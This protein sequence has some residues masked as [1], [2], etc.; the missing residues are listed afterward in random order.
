[1]D[2]ETLKILGTAAGLG[3]LVGLQKEIK[4][5][6]MAGIRTFTL[7]TLFGT[8][9]G[10]LAQHLEEGFIIA[11]GAVCLALLISIVNFRMPSNGD[12]GLGQTTEVALL[13]MYALGAYL[14]YGQLAIGVGVGA[15]TALLLYM[16][17]TLGE[18]VDR[19][20]PK[21]IRAIMQF[22]AISLVILPIL[23][24]QTFGPYGVLNPR[25]IW[26]MVVL[27]VGLG[28]IG[29][30]IYKW[31]GND[32][33]TILNGI[34]GGLISSTATT[35]TFS[36]RAAQT[37]KAS[38]V[39]AFIVMAASTIAVVR[40]LI[41]VIIVSPSNIGVIGPP[42]LVELAFMLLLCAGLYWYSKKQET[43]KLPEPQ[44]PAQLK[45]ALIFGALYAV[46]LLAVAAG[47]DFFG[48]NGLYIVSI[49]SG[50]TDVDAITLSL[51]NS[52]N[53]GNLANTVAWKLILIAS[54]S[55][56]IFKGGLVVT[57]GTKQMSRFV[58]VVFGLSVVFG[59]LLIWLWPESWVI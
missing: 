35:V 9:M 13:L 55:N 54:L 11:A 40:V 20:E 34:L 37:P 36:K 58:I 57:L 28:L 2:Y 44:N 31:V 42:L 10:L 6:K 17:S 25:E 24:N 56:L 18:F 3:L 38:V 43:E 16:K 33:G 45:S 27:I 14:V 19:L 41:E 51:A 32:A 50:L 8:I 49:L 21:D 30:F 1:M 52:V 7:T 26:M 5:D 46:I 12:E 23:P 59:L 4:D 48:Q 47:K 29:Y 22:A 53:K 39:T 15:V